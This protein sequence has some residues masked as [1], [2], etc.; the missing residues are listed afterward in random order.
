MIIGES[1]EDAGDAGLT[2]GKEGG[3]LV[4]DSRRSFI[5][6]QEWIREPDPNGPDNS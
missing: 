5:R 2:T 1:R 6:Q 3:L 4:H